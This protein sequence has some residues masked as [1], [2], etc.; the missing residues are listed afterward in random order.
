MD[1][2]H[3]S[4][5]PIEDVVAKLSWRFAKSM[6]KIPHWYTVRQ[7]KD[8]ELNA[9]YCRLFQHIAEN[10]YLQRFFNKEYKY[11]NIGEFKY[12]IMA[13]DVKD[14]TIINRARLE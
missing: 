5:M 14:S 10:F 12:W 13:D 4:A 3:I 1:L 6:P 11:C 2:E 7:R 9:L 8:A